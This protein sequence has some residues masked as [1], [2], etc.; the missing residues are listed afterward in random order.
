MMSNRVLLQMHLDHHALLTIM[1]PLRRSQIAGPCEI[2]HCIVK[3]SFV[4]L[5]LMVGCNILLRELSNSQPLGPTDRAK[6]GIELA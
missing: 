2:A 6:Y 3:T 4:T 5:T 1:L